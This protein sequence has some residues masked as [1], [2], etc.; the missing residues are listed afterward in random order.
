MWTQAHFLHINSCNYIIFGN[1][2]R[3]QF[4]I[5]NIKMR[6]EMDSSLRFNCWEIL[7]CDNLD[8]LARR[9]PD[10]PCWEIAQRHE[11]Y[12]NVSNTCRD[13]VVYKL[14]EVGSAL[15]IKQLREFRKEREVLPNTRIGH[16]VCI[17]R[18]TLMANNLNRHNYHFLLHDFIFTW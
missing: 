5:L 9:E 11:S 3:L 4:C 12:Q 14:D 13:C 18:Q 7:N 2:S 10:I 8:C 1:N 15:S 6:W 16:Q 17:R